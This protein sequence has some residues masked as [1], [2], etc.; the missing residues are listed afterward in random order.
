MKAKDVAAHHRLT[1]D[2]DHVALQQAENAEVRG[3]DSAFAF[4]RL[5]EVHAPRTSESV[6]ASLGHVM[7]QVG[8]C[9]LVHAGLRG[10]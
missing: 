3:H 7:R 5:V 10:C 8:D 9:S 6:E 4:H 2:L 1:C